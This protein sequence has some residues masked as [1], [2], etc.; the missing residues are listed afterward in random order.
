[1]SMVMLALVPTNLNYMGRP[2][3]A[4]KVGKNLKAQSLDPTIQIH[5]QGHCHCA[6]LVSVGLDQLRQGL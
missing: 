5:N 1:M 2:V 6:S 4:Q 3:S